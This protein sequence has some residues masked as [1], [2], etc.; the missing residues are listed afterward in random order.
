MQP[1]NITLQITGI[2]VFCYDAGLHHPYLLVFLLLGFGG[3]PSQTPKGLEVFLLQ[4]IERV[5]A[6]SSAH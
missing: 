5:L 3:H 2:A 1:P 6:F 4:L